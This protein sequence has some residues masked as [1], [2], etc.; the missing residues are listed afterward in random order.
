MNA[1]LI[2]YSSRFN[3]MTLRERGLIVIAVLTILILIWDR[4]LM[5]PLELK[6]QL[7]SQELSEVQ[8]NLE[9]VSA[10]IEGRANSDPLSLAVTQRKSLERSLSAV[11]TQLQST[12]AGL[13]APQKMLSA[14]RDMLDRQQGVR[15]ISMRNLPVVSLVPVEDTSH[16]IAN[17]AQL[18]T[19]PIAPSGPYLHPIEMVIDGS[20]LDVLRY[21]Q[22]VEALPWKFYWQS[23]ELETTEY[24]I[25]RVRLRLNTLS[26]DK[27]WLGV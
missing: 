22:N 6:K 18:I 12:A 23:L 16:T 11:D 7:L 27:E 20:Y 13:I 4:L 5:H 3:A 24:P 25:N 1:A 15:L 8:K 14:M 10:S 21:L 9:M 17:G 2:N 26:M 19:H